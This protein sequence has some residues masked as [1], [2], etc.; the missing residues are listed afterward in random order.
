[1]TVDL[2]ALVSNWRS[3]D[4][5]SSDTTE[6]GAVVKA[7]GYGLG[8]QPVV[9]ALAKAGV[10]RYFVAAAEEGAAVRETL[11]PN[12]EINVFSGHMR[13]DTD[14]IGDL[15][16]IPMINSTDQLL[17]HVEALPGH[18]FGIQ[19]DTGMN[20]LGIEDHRRNGCRS[21][22]S[23]WTSTRRLSCRTSPAR[24]SRTTR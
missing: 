3:L 1:M 8:V 14:M 5:A 2:D 17:R 22:T 9:R 15:N 13:G 6:T 20:R 24:M 23:R 12:V 10:K 11:G 16:L 19:L 21:A 7:N 4:S 18:G